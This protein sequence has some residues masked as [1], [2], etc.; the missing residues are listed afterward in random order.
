MPLSQKCSDC[1]CRDSCLKIDLACQHLLFAG[2][3]FFC[4]ILAI[5][6][7]TCGKRGSINILSGNEVSVEQ[8]VK[9]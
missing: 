3:M 6:I 8:S 7:G 4:L 9:D 5:V 1:K 2:F